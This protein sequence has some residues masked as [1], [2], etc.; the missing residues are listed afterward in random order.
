MLTVEADIDT[1]GALG[2]HDDVNGVVFA[3]VKY[4]GEETSVTLSHE[5]LEE[6]G[7]PACDL[8]LSLGDGREQ[9]GEACDRVEGDTYSVDGVHLSNYLLLAAFQPDSTG[10]WDK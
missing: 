7:D 3:R 8:Y 10:P 9:A 4:Q 1:P 5:V 6:M 2:F